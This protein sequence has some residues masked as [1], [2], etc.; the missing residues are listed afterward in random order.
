[1]EKSNLGIG[2]LLIC[3]SGRT[4]IANCTKPATKTPQ[5]N[6]NI[7]ISNI[8]AINTAAVINET[9]NIIGVDAGKENL[10]WVF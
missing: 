4:W 5:A 7:G 10:P 8:G 1:M 6:A 3:L 2:S 9:L